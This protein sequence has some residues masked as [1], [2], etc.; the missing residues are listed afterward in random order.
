MVDTDHLVERL[1]ELREEGDIDEIDSPERLV[2]FREPD[3]KLNKTSVN[4]FGDDNSFDCR[5]ISNENGK[6]VPVVY[7][8]VTSENESVDKLF[9]FKTFEKSSN[10]IV[11]IFHLIKVKLSWFGL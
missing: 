7:L 5:V 1:D 8:I 2:V 6:Y 3:A 10:V 4:I 9:N 11:D